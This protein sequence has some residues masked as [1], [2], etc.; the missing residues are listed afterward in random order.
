MYG[1]K[2]N[3]RAPAAFNPPAHRAEIERFAA[4][5]EA[6]YGRL[7]TARRLE[8]VLDAARAA[9]E[10]IAAPVRKEAAIIEC[11]AAR[12]AA[13]MGRVKKKIASHRTPLAKCWWAELKKAGVDAA[14]HAAEEALRTAAT[15]LNVGLRKLASITMLERPESWW[16]RTFGRA[17][18]MAKS[19]NDASSA[20]AREFEQALG[21]ATQQ[22]LDA[23]YLAACELAR[24]ERDLLPVDL[25]PVPRANGRADTLWKPRTFEAG[26]NSFW[27]PRS[28]DRLI[29]EITDF[30]MSAA[31]TREKEIKQRFAE[32]LR[33]YADVQFRILTTRLDRLGLIAAGHEPA[34]L[35]ETESRLSQPLAALAKFEQAH[36]AACDAVRALQLR[37]A[38]G[39]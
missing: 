2:P 4:W 18:E 28:I 13:M 23:C 14:E 20:L 6:G 12:D 26:P 16:A 7:A 22:Y 31:N 30:A 10:R 21:K 5:F 27:I 37:A 3:V 9:A 34:L 8:K 32:R 35:K 1:L 39:K 25:G 38:R 19:L 17:Q 33:W 24:S 11:I 15:H 29:D 36:T